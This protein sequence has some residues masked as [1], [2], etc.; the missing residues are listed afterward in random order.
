MQISSD[1]LQTI[2]YLSRMLATL[3]QPTEN[4][5]SLAESKVRLITFHSHKLGFSSSK[6]CAE[7][8]KSSHTSISRDEQVNKGMILLANNTQKSEGLCKTKGRCRGGL[9]Y[10]PKVPSKSNQTINER[11]NGAET[12]TTEEVSGV[13]TKS[14]MPLDFI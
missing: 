14:Q 4:G 7:I 6:Y 1:V 10:F 2:A 8:Q 5:Q 3:F 9:V 11:R 13:P 12:Y